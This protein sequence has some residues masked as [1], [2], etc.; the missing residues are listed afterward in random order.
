MLYFFFS[1][2]SDKEREGC[3]YPFLAR[4]RNGAFARGAFAEEA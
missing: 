2:K 3:I 4:I 1:K